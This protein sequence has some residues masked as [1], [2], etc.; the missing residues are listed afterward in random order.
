V[1]EERARADDP[2]SVLLQLPADHEHPLAVLRR[3]DLL[4]AAEAVEPLRAPALGE[5]DVHLEAIADLCSRGSGAGTDYH[6]HM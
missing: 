1:A 3:A 5:D 4:Q 6:S 2:V